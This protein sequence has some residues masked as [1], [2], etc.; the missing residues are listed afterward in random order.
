MT[1]LRNA[2]GWLGGHVRLAI[3][4]ALIALLVSVSGFA[5]WQWGHSQQQD[6][7]RAELAS[8]VAAANGTI[9]GLVQDNRAQD[10]AINAL[11]ELRAKDAKA[12]TGLQR[13]ITH[14]DRRS[15]SVK[16][17]LDQLER[18][19]ARAKT[20]LDTAVPPDTGCVLDGRAC[21]GGEPPHASSSRASH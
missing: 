20:L 13:D 15:L 21:P 2:M 5:L 17:K 19:N 7:E 1:L 12:I 10:Q 18:N 14:A 3:E 8:K 11:R 4:Y 16:T 6:K 9:D